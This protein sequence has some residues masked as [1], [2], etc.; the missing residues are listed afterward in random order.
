MIKYKSILFSGPMVRA[1]LEGRKTQTRRIVKPQPDAEGLSKL[2]DG[3]WIYAGEKTYR[4]PYGQLGYRLWVRETFYYEEHMHD[5]TAG[6]PD[7]PDGRF[8]HRCIYRAD[9]PDYPVNI[10]VGPHGWRPSIFMPRWASRI[11]LEITDIRA[12][13][14]QEISEEDAKAEGVELWNTGWPKDHWNYENAMRCKDYKNYLWHGHAK[15]AVMKAWEHQYSN[16]PNAKGSFSS[17][18][19]S[20]NGLGSW[21]A[22]PWVWAISFRLVHP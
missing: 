20:I 13:R 5:V 19:E 4:C 1:I 17:L 15:G 7:L 9:N 21:D 16:Y 12:Q 14:L 22:N 10:G 3:P 8:S 2:I 6:A 18:W 11:T